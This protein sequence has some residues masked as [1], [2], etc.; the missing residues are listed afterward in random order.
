MG[1]AW[2]EEEIIQLLKLVQENKSISEISE[3]HQ[4]TKGGIV[5]RLKGSLAAHTKPYKTV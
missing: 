3:I 1:K 4:R 2:K 5:C